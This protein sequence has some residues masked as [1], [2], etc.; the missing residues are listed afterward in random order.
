MFSKTS[1]IL[2]SLC[3]AV[4][5]FAGPLDPPPGPVTDSEQSLGYKT[6]FQVEPRTP[7]A[8]AD[9]PVQITQPGS[10]YL[11]ENVPFVGAS[12]EHGIE[13]LV[14]D[15][16]LDLNGFYLEGANEVAAGGTGIRALNRRNIHIK[17]GTV[18]NWSIG[19]ISLSGSE[20]CI[21]GHVRVENCQS[22][23]IQAGTRAR[24]HDC[25]VLGSG[26]AGIS[27]SGSTISGCVVR[28][29]G[30]D[31]IFTSSGSSVTNSISHG[32]TARGIVVSAG[33][34]IT[35]CGSAQNGSWGMQASNGSSIANCGSYQDSAGFDALDGSTITNSAARDHQFT[36][37]ISVRQGSLAESC[38]VYQGAGNGIQ[39]SSGSTVRNCNVSDVTGAGV[40][41]QFSFSRCRIEGNSVTD[42]G[43]GFDV[44]VGLSGNLIISNSASGNG[45]NY[46]FAANN[47]VGQVINVAG[48][49]ITSN[50]P[51]ANL[52]Y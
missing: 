24:V 38:T 30:G 51:W 4:A 34:S 18:R 7:I 43:T 46:N 25:T 23:G 52:S 49:T 10:Y 32:N 42:S 8:A 19:G 3:L 45:L 13:I 48:A 15:V 29:S 37:G 2:S 41:V 14:D 35:S 9:F 50:N 21:I 36:T 27:A 39:V 17:N 47:A 12:G 33:G 26:G 5:A 6:L 1:G 11:V 20:N 44:T 40:I 16:T 22:T 31:G 28:G